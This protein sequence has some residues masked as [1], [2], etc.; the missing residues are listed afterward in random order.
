MNKFLLLNHLDEY[1]F[2]KYFPNKYTI[3]DDK[4]PPWMTKAIKD[5]INSKKFLCQ[6]KITQM[7]RWGPPWI[8]VWHSL[9]NLKNNYLLKKLLKR[10]NK[11]CKYF[12]VYKNEKKIIKIKKN[13]WRHH[14]FTP[15]YQQSSWYDHSSWDIECDRLKLVIM[16]HFCPFTLPLPKT[17]KIRIFKKW[18]KKWWRY[19]HSQV[20]QKP[21]SYEVKFLR[22][23]VKQK[24]FC[25]IWA[26]LAILPPNN[27]K[28]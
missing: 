9:M 11:K 18:K 28:N 20:Y 5:K 2:N 27:W 3:I 4:D 6:S 23:G 12:N 8:S 26:F 15:S 21:Q 14:Y 1:F 16:N 10:A 19:H 7:W 24:E 25:I 13:T 22:Y 17:Q